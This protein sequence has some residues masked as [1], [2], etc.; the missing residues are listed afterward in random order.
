MT[1]GKLAVIDTMH[2]AWLQ[3]SLHKLTFGIFSENIKKP[4]QE[5]LDLYWAC[6]FSFN[7]LKAIPLLGFNVAMKLR[8]RQKMT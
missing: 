8:I 6:L 4:S 3:F 2:A 5:K 1:Y 7:R